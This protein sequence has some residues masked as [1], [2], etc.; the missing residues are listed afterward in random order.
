MSDTPK[1]DEIVRRLSDNG[2]CSS[3][4]SNFAREL[5][6][7]NAKLKQ[8]RDELLEALVNMLELYVGL[9]NGGD[10]GF[11]D[12][13]KEDEVKAARAAIAKAKGAQP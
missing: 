9:A 4:L 6:R 7:E 11:W 13:E 2:W 10:C 12:A 5:E 1:T 8:Q 3:A